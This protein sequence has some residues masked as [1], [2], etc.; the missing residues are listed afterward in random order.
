MASVRI[1]RRALATPA[2]S[3]TL[4]DMNTNRVDYRFRT[5]WSLAQHLEAVWT[6]LDNPSAWPR[7]WPGCMIVEPL[8]RE[9]VQRP[10]CCYRFH[11]QGALPYRLVIRICIT[12]VEHRRRMIGRVDGPLVGTA[13]WTLWT[14]ARHTKV[15]FDFAVSGHAAWTRRVAPF[16]RPLFRWNHE[17]LM[18]R[19]ESGL[20]E[21]L[22]E[23]HH[24]K[25]H[26]LSTGLG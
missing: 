3:P 9:S 5:V 10:G 25:H 2:G 22:N 18:A 24:A 11:W 21:W 7:W 4:M 17:A 13:E 23:R 8:T 20:R 6:A 14:E 12:A 26:G 1:V 16:A 19:G 15:G